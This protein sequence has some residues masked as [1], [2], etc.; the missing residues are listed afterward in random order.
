MALDEESEDQSYYSSSWGEHEHL[1]YISSQFIQQL[2]RCFNKNF[3]FSTWW[4]SSR[5]NWRPWMFVQRFVPV[6]PIVEIFQS[7]PKWW[8]DWQH[9]YNHICFLKGLLVNEWDELSS[10]QLPRFER[11]CALIKANQ[12]RWQQFTTWCIYI[13]VYGKNLQRTVSTQKQLHMMLSW[14]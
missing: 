1:N 7:G 14:T 5:K 8:T 6:H 9:S 2:L 4:W 10:L 12:V 13:S 3:K 11:R